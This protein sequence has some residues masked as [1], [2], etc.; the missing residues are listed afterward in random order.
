MVE[1]YLLTLAAALVTAGV[2]G[3]FSFIFLLQES[4]LKEKKTV[5]I[6]AAGVLGYVAAII[7]FEQYGYGIGKQERYF[8]LMCAL[9]VLAFTDRI[10][11][12]IPNRYLLFLTILRIA[13]LAAEMIMLPAM[14]MDYLIYAFGG[15]AGSFL[16]MLAAYLISQKKVGLG[17]VKLMAVLGFYVGFAGCY[18][19]LFLALLFAAC[20]GV[21]KLLRKKVSLQDSVPFAPFVTAGMFAAFLLGV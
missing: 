8:I 2:M 7:L 3:G 19:I 11:R 14:W 13:V 16:L 4:L 9:P 10:S 21:W 15:A 6:W 1:H 17:D 12:R 18:R 20:W 5:W